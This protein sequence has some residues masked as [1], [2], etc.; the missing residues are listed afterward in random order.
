MKSVYAGFYLALFFQLQWRLKTTFW[1]ARMQLVRS[2]LINV[3]QLNWTQ[4]K[5]N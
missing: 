3:L 4:Q 2:K 5:R 1:P